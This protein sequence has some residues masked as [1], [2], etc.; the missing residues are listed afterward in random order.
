M[1][2]T[3]RA[4]RSPSPASRSRTIAFQSGIFDPRNAPYRFGELQPTLPLRG[5]HFAPRRSQPVK[6]PPPLPRLLH[7][8][9]LNPTAPLEPV[10]QAIQRRH[11]ERERPL[12]PRRNQLADLIPMPRTLFKQRQDQQLRAAL[13]KFTL[14]HIY[15]Y[16]TYLL[17]TGI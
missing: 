3:S 10:Q 9:A 12:R 2:S 11:L 17:P 15:R 7:P 14:S 16:T 6:A 1:I 13:L 8:A 4:P 5:E